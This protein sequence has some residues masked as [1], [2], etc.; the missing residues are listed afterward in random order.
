MNNRL[1]EIYKSNIEKRTGLKLQTIPQNSNYEIGK[2]YYSGYWNETFQVLEYKELPSSW[3]RFSVKCKWQDGKITNH[4]TPL[5]LSKD[6]FLV[7]Q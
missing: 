3:M 6:D 7:I 1:L 4:C 5:N 2:T